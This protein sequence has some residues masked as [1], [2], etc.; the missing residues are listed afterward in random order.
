MNGTVNPNGTLVLS[1]KFEYGPHTNYGTTLPC[2]DPGFGTEPV[3]V[4]AEATGLTP[5]TSYHYRIVATTNAAPR[6]APIRNSK[7]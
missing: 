7:P 3:P 1:C 6:S 5:D 2:S 4:S